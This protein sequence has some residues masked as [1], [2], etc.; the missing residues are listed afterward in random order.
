MVRAAASGDRDAFAALV[1]QHQSLVFGLAWNSLRNTAIAEELAQD[2]FLELYSAL[3]DLE[4]N[5]HVVNWLRRVTLHRCIDHVRRERNH[6]KVG[7][8]EIAEPMAAENGSQ[9]DAD[10]FLSQRVRVLTASLPPRARAVLLLRYQEEL[11]PPEIADVLRIPVNTVKSQLHRSL[12]LLR[13]KL[14][15]TR[16]AT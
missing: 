13:S 5:A 3:P 1:R 14:Q 8:D 11:D 4:S 10:P 7:L 15:R 9:G 16:V 12:A 6:P 2:V